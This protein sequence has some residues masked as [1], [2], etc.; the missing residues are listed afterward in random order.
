MI[1]IVCPYCKDSNDFCSSCRGTKEI[2]EYEY[3][4]NL[5]LQAMVHDSINIRQKILWTFVRSSIKEA[6]NLLKQSMN[7][8]LKKLE[9]EIEEYIDLAN[10]LKSFNEWSEIFM[11]EV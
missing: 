10:M 9:N 1:K 5:M 7:E 11:Q 2:R 6:I 3:I 8:D 4:G